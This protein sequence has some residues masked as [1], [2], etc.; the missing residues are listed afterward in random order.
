MRNAVNEKRQCYFDRLVSIAAV[1]QILLWVEPEQSPTVM[2]RFRSCDTMATLYENGQ[3]FRTQF[4][5]ICMHT[6]MA[7]K[8]FDGKTMDKIICTSVLISEL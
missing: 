2:I 1:K 8:K 4:F 6:G 5:R 7:T 3:F